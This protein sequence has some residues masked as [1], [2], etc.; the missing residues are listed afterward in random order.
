MLGALEDADVLSR[1]TRTSDIIEKDAQVLVR[2][3]AR[4]R[5]RFIAIA[6]Y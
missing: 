6:F 1:D 4:E 2:M 3:T 5:K